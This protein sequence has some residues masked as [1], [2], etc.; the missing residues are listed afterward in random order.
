M[1]IL[2]NFFGNKVLYGTKVAF[3]GLGKLGL[4]CAEAIVKKGFDVTGYDTQK[5]RSDLVQ[6]KNNLKETV[7]GRDIIFIAVPTPHEPGYDGR[8]PTSNKEVKDFDYTAVKDTLLRL[9]GICDRKQIIVLISTVLP[10]TIRR[11]FQP[12]LTNT[13]LVYNP[14]LIAMGTVADDM[15]NPE[16]IMIGTEKGWD[17]PVCAYKMEVLTNFYNTVCDNYP[18]IETGTWEEVESMKI[19]YNTFISNKIALVNMIQDV[20]NKIGY[21]DV[22]KVTT[23]LGMS[24]KRIV[25]A[26]YMKAGM[27]DG[28]AC[29]PRDNIALRWLAKDLGLGYDLFESIMTA[30]ERQAELMAIAI[31]EHGENVH[32]TSD[33]YKP[34]TALVDGSYSLL[35]QH[36]VIKHGGTIVHGFD[37]PVQVIVRVHETDKVTACEKTV[38]FDPWRSYPKAKNVV[39]YGKYT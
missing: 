39:Y 3:I 26:A 2:E 18:R 21:M 1:G 16:M 38:I 10:G 27:G 22:D 9:N 17:G 35:V 31:L 37:T 29:H 13:G 24:T 5:K 14:Y 30:R 6:I 36:Y 33:S 7:E 32:F 12:L 19:F 34:G 15:V 11:E 28:G 23:A 20:A 4:P 25:S 8:E